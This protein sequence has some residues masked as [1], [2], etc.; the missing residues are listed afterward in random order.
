MNEYKLVTHRYVLLTVLMVQGSKHIA[1]H[2]DKA[3]YYM[4]KYLYISFN[5][6]TLL[7]VYFKSAYIFLK[8]VKCYIIV[9][10]R[11]WEM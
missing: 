5:E 1:F 2:V 9:A 4:V 3:G 11:K 10:G 8:N 7:K 6:D